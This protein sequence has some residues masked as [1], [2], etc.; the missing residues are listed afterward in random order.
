MSETGKESV[1]LIV[2]DSDADYE[3]TRR[4]I[5]KAGLDELTHR[6]CSGGE[7]ALDYLMKRGE[8]EAPGAAPTPSLILLDL[9]MPG[10]GGRETLRIMKS[11]ANLRKIPVVVMTNSQN[12]K[13]IDFC[14]ENGANSY[15]RKS[16]DWKNFQKAVAITLSFWVGT[17]ILSAPAQAAMPSGF[18]YAQERQAAFSKSSLIE[19]TAVQP[20]RGFAEMCEKRPELC[21]AESVLD[22]VDGMS[23]AVEGMYGA[24]AMTM[25][26]PEATPAR[27]AALE[28]VN[29]AVNAS[30]TP[31]SDA[32]PDSWD[33]G[34]AAGDC[35]DYVLMKREL[36]A[37]VGWPRSALRITVVHDGTGYHA[38]LLAVTQQGEFVLDNMSQKVTSVAESPYQFVV[39]Q[40]LAK[41]GAWVRVSRG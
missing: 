24:A 33:L 6:R 11:T 27:M 22:D 17:A 15:V 37:R 30:I 36:L 19:S 10:L 4:A 32:G 40:S 9:N 12:D 23:L 3:L 28:R 39:A 5:Q 16:F 29:S 35:E 25:M 38:A 21:P 34:A 7:E 41:P 26:A 8:F 20:P 18:D 14:Y 31:R 13:D 1:V 2:D